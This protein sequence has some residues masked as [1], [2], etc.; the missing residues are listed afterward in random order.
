[1]S[2]YIYSG[3]HPLFHGDFGKSRQLKYIR[4]FWQLWVEWEMRFLRNPQN[5][6]AETGAAD[7]EYQQCPGAPTTLTQ[8]PSNKLMSNPIQPCLHGHQ[9][10]QPWGIGKSWPF[11]AGHGGG[12][13]N[14]RIP[15]G[16]QAST[17]NPREHQASSEQQVTEAAG[18]QHSCLALTTDVDGFEGHIWVSAFS[19]G[20]L[21]LHEWDNGNIWDIPGPH[22][23]NL[24][25]RVPAVTGKV[26]IFGSHWLWDLG[27]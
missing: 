15:V 11:T 20:E 25:R 27:K 4:G 17:L 6:G 22:W 23:A 19:D 16:R 8:M 26:A 5:K 3:V 21:C 24:C 2:Y 1:M 10:R 7:N 13:L 18:T 12:S 9:R 14:R